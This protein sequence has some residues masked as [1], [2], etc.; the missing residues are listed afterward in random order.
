MAD[1]IDRQAAMDIIH[2]CGGDE[3][4]PPDMIEMRGRLYK[5]P[6]VDAVEV[7]R[8]KDCRHCLFDLSGREA[9]LCMKP[10]VTLPAR[11]RVKAE[12]FCSDGK[13]RG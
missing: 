6:T 2:E 13:R 10:N 1:L 5:L 3:I 12:D 11:K 8:C 9:H 4:Y 7:V